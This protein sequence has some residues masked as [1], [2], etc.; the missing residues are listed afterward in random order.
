[1]KILKE[2][3][4]NKSVIYSIIDDLKKTHLNL[5]ILTFLCTKLIEQLRRG[6]TKPVSKSNYPTIRPSIIFLS[7]KKVVP[8][9]HDM[10]NQLFLHQL[11]NKL[12]LKSMITKFSYMEALWFCTTFQDSSDFQ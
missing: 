1:M 5:Y 10:I 6:N 4:V 9:D 8:L 7:K 3:L 12:F 2:T 11:P